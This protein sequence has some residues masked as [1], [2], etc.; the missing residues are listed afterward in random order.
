MENLDAMAY[1]E[2]LDQR[3]RKEDQVLLAGLDP[4]A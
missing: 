1:M 2:Y 3:V 4:L